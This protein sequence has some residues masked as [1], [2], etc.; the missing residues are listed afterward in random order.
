MSTF[1]L[2]ED[3]CAKQNVD[4]VVNAANCN[5]AEGLG[6]CGAI[7][8]M[9]GNEELA[10]ECAKHKTPLHDGDA[11]IT[12]SC[13]MTNAKAIIHA[14]GPNFSRKPNSFKEL[15]DAYYNSLVVLKDNGYHSIS[16]PLIS[17]GIFGGALTNT[18]AESTRQCVRAY[19]K[20]C[21]DFPDYNVDVILCA[22]KN[23]EFMAAQAE[24]ASQ[25][26]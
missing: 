5:L 26:I 6:I 15:F 25:E 3:S 9:A 14:V 12:S 23:I 24:C 21:S 1:Q 8:D 2:I 22:F 19:R 4:V 17:S 11:V 16:F 20:F 13:R 18:V 10:V 7:F